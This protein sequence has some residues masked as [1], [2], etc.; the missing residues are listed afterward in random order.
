MV[1]SVSGMFNASIEID[2]ANAYPNVRLFTVGQ[3]TQSN[4]VPLPQLASIEQ[5]WS[6]ASNTSITD[7]NDFGFFSAV[8]WLH[9]KAIH[10][11]TGAPVGLISS[12]WGGTEIELWS[13]P[14]ALAACNKTGG[15]PLYNAMIAPYTVGPMALSGML[16][17]QGDL[18][19]TPCPA[20]VRV[21]VACMACAGAAAALAC[22]SVAVTTAAPPSSVLT[23][24]LQARLTRMPTRLS[25]TRAPS[26]R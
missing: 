9:G 18:S 3:K 8:C 13:P 7:G 24:T 25:T 6:V 2:S 4:N 20:R 22:C 1:F 14:S 15:S 10:D 17:Y 19:A 12:N 26:Q 16:W 11:A 5:G 21:R 23:V